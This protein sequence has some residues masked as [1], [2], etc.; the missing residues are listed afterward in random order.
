MRYIALLRGINVGGNTMIKMTDLKT[1]FEQCGFE[2]VVTYINSGNIAFDIDRLQLPTLQKSARSKGVRDTESTLTT[3]IEQTIEKQF[4]KQIPVII[5]EQPH[6]AHILINNLF[7]G[8]FESH[9]EMHVL[10]LKEEMPDEK[11]DQL[12]VAAPEK[13]RF[14]VRGR[15]IY[16]HLPMGVADSLLGKSFIEKKMKVAVTGRNWRTVEKL[17]TL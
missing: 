12:L 2:N 9:K 8:Q 11:I 16:C 6:I 10:F 15:E 5:R 3:T 14:A 4:A 1:A 13:E 7:A 17:V